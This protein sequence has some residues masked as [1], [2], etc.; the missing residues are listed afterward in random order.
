MFGG[1]RLDMSPA[2]PLKLL[3]IYCLKVRYLVPLIQKR[4]TKIKMTDLFIKYD[5]FV[6]CALSTEI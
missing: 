6:R 3:V 5:L 4:P 2:L 1:S